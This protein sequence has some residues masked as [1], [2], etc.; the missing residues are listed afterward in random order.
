[1]ASISNFMLILIYFLRHLFSLGLWGSYV[2]VLISLFLTAVLHRRKHHI[3]GAHTS[4]VSAKSPQTW[5]HKLESAESSAAQKPSEV[6]LHLPGSVVK[7]SPA[8]QETQ[9]WFLGWEEPMGKEMATHSSILFF[10]F[11]QFFILF[12]SFVF[13]SWRLITLQ[14][15]RGFCHTL[16][17]IS[18]GFTC[19]LHPESPS[20]LPPY[21]IP[22]GLPS[23]P[24]PSTCLMHPTWAGDLFHPW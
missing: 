4:H 13:I 14:Y 5:S 10:F 3:Q 24:A 18:H 2:K 16:T 12:F 6:H 23:A 22:L 8:K 21:P 15:C 9:V 17:W 11:Y 1:M 20:H 19:V 7:N